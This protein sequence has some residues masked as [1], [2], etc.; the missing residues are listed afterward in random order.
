MK[1]IVFAAAPYLNA[2]PLTEGMRERDDVAL[3]EDR[4]SA[5]SD[6]VRDGRADA[7]LLPVVAVLVDPELAIL[8]GLGVCADGAVRSVLLRCRRPIGEVRTVAGDPAS[9]TSN[10]LALLLLRTRCQSNARLLPGG[11]TG[12]ADAVVVIGDRALQVVPG[13]PGD[14]DLA[15][16]WKD[17]T[18]LPFVFAVWAYRRGHPQARKLNRIATDSLAAGERARDAIAV[19][20]A[21]RLALPLPVCRDYLMSRVHYRIGEREQ[22][23]IAEFGRRLNDAS[24]L[25]TET[26]PSL[27]TVS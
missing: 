4:P 17:M 18:G 6:Y 2:A 3:I 19:R 21:E 13:G 8:D 5:L 23:A 16:A 22:R 11:R 7:G 26:K 24:L 27:R 12:D 15:E 20:F 10:L 14:I 9:R 1:R 25:P